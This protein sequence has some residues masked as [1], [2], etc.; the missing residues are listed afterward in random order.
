[1]AAA[2]SGTSSFL[3]HPGQVMSIGHFVDSSTRPTRGFLGSTGFGGHGT[4]VY[5]GQPGNVSALVGQGREG[6]L[7]PLPGEAA[8]S[9]GVRARV[10]IR[11]R[12]EP[13]DV[14][15]AL[16]PAGS[17][18]VGETLIVAAVVEQLSGA[19]TRPSFAT[20]CQFLAP[21]QKGQY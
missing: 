6:A 4:T 19:F 15:D 7:V 10:G 21:R 2:L 16:R 18:R 9:F 14:T 11:S 3:A 1:L 8:Q 17:G 12:P 20:A 13:V 5:R